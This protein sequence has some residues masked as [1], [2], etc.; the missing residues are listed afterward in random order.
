MAHVVAV[1]DSSLALQDGRIYTAQA[2]GRQRDDGRWEGWLEF[3]PDDP[4]VV[5]R[6]ARE[7]TQRNLPDLEHWASTLTPVYLQGALER[8]LT[9]TSLVVAEP[10][11]PPVYDEPAPGRIVPAVYDEP[12]P[13]G[14]VVTPMLDPFAEFPRGEEDLARHLATLS[15]QH[16]RAIIVENNLADPTVDLDAL[17]VPELVGWIIGAVR[18]R[19]AS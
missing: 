16:L 3:V 11:A 5:L 1:F 14:P 17:T 10:A 13:R 9:P 15:P 2:C 19:L 8:A 7:T 18:W 6:T 4:S 12:A